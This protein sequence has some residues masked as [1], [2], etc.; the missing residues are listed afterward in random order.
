[1]FVRPNVLFDF[2][3]SGTFKLFCMELSTKINDDACWPYSTISTK[4][5][6]CRYDSWPY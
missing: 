6:S 2:D 1:V 5:S 4:K 3:V